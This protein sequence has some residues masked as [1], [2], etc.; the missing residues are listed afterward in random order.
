M[1]LDYNIVNPDLQILNYIVDIVI[2]VSISSNLTFLIRKTS[3]F[4]LF[5]LFDSI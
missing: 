3:F 2:Y 1:L 4:N 5:I